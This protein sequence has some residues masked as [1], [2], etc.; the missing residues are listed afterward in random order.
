MQYKI[1]YDIGLL[2]GPTVKL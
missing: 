1:A 2:F